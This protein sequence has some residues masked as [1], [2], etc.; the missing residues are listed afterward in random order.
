MSLLWLLALPLMAGA[1]P[2]AAI[3]GLCN[4]NDAQFYLRHRDGPG[5]DDCDAA[6]HSSCQVSSDGAWISHAN[7][8]EDLRLGHHIDIFSDPARPFCI[9]HDD[10]DN[11][12]YGALNCQYADRRQLATVPGLWNVVVSPVGDVSLWEPGTRICPIEPR[13]CTVNRSTSQWQYRYTISGSVTE[14]WKHGTS[15]RHEES[16]TETWDESMTISVSQSFGFLGMGGE[17]TITGSLAHSTAREFQDE[18]STTDEQEFSVTWDKSDI[19][20]ASWQFIWNEFDTCSHEEHTKTREFA[21]TANRLDEPCCLPGYATDAP[22]Y[23]VCLSEE[24]MVAN[25]KD[26]G[27]SVQGAIVVV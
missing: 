7:S 22:H 6:P 20:K 27:C 8:A 5:R 17:I 25:G 21:V 1:A 11:K 9:W 2:T 16:K 24:V 3:K 13:N 12:I 14:T 4:Q 26:H 19:G 23:K 18:W 10:Y 15:K